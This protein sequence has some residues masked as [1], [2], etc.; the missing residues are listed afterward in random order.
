MTIYMKIAV[1]LRLDNILHAKV[2]IYTPQILSSSTALG[3]QGSGVKWR[4]GNNDRDL[5]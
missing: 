4:G 1:V 3:D 5:S 2:M